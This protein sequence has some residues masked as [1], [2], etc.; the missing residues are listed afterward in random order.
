MP[1]LNRFFL[2]FLYNRRIFSLLCLYFFF[3]FLHLP[4]KYLQKFR[5]YFINLKQTQL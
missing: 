1:V 2:F 3:F 5:I 4:Q